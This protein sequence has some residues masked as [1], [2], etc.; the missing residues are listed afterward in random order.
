MVYCRASGW[1][2]CVG[3]RIWVILIKL[4][5]YVRLAAW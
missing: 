4:L 1:F 5:N 2:V 3:M